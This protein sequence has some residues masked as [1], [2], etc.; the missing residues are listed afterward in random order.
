M[1][2]PV[3]KCFGDL[4]PEEVFDIFLHFVK[5]SDYNTSL[6]KS[7]ATSNQIFATESHSDDEANDE[8]T[9]DL[10]DQELDDS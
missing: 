1:G 5:P 10:I 7:L 3:F 9:K 2:I 6:F 8:D 4:T